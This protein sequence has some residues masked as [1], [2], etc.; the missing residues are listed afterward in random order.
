MLVEKDP[1]VSF[2]PLGIKNPETGELKRIE[3][4]ASSDPKIAHLQRKLANLVA[5]HVIKGNTDIETLFSTLDQLM[6][7]N[8]RP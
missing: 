7:Y 3:P 8:I 6:N 5:E 2:T 1:I 4:V